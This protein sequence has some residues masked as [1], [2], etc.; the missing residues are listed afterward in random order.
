ML[1]GIMRIHD[2]DIVNEIAEKI[3]DRLG[4]LYDFSEPI[5]N[6]KNIFLQDGG[7]AACIWSAPRVYECH[8]LFPPECRG[9]QAV[10]ASRRMGDYMM[11]YH[12]DMLWGKPPEADK[13]A[14]WHIRQ[15]GF[16]EQS[17][18]YDPA[19]GAVVYF[20]RRK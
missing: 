8:L 4:G 12:A 20:V 17:R 6:P 2:P 19:M 14:C 11:A 1:H 9:R 3:T 10:D 15:A 13:P 5:S 7:V 16:V 18:G